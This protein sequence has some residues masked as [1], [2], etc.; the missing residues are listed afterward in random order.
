[1]EP[2]LGTGI[3]AMKIVLKLVIDSIRNNMD[4][5]EN[6][7]SQ[8]LGL[9]KDVC[10]LRD[11]IMKNKKINPHQVKLIGDLAH[12]IRD[13][14][15]KS[16]IHRS[17][18]KS[19]Y[20]SQTAKLDLAKNVQKL[21]S[22]VSAVCDGPAG[23]PTTVVEEDEPPS[24]IPLR[25]DNVVGFEDEAKK[26]INYLMEE[27]DE[28]DV[29]SIVGMPGL[30][31]STL[32]YKIHKDQD[33][34]LAPKFPASN[35]IWVRVQPRDES[36]DVLRSILRQI[37]GVVIGNQILEASELRKR[38]RDN[39]WTLGCFLITIDDVWSIK[40]WKD[41]ENAFP[42]AHKAG[43]IL[44][45]SQLLDVARAVNRK[46][47][48]HKLRFLT[49]IECREL[50][51][52]EVF[53]TRECEPGQDS[54]L[55]SVST[56]CDGLPHLILG[57]AESVHKRDSKW[58]SE[59]FSS[60][61][62]DFIRSPEE[63]A[64][65]L[66]YNRLPDHLKLCFLYMGIFPESYVL[67][68]PTYEIPVWVL[69]R[70][71]LAEDF[72][73]P[74]GEQVA[75]DYLMDLVNRNL[76]MMIPGMISANESKH[77]RVHCMVREFCRYEAGYDRGNVFQE[78]NFD[79]G[80]FQPSIADLGNPRRLRIGS[81]V[82]GFFRFEKPPPHVSSFICFST[83]DLE[84]GDN[85]SSIPDVLEYLRV[86]EAKSITYNKSWGDWR[87]MLLLKHLVLSTKLHV[88]PKVISKLWSLETLVVHTTASVLK[89]EAN[90]YDMSYL[91]H[92]ET[93]KPT[94]LPKPGKSKKHNKLLTLGTISDKSCTE[95]M[96]ARLGRLQ[97]LRIHG[98]IYEV[99]K[100]KSL[101][102]LDSLTKLKFENESRSNQP[103]SKAKLL[104]SYKFPTNLTSLTLS[105]TRL[106]WSN[107]SALELL[108]RLE[109]LKLKNN[110][111]SGH[112]WVVG[113]AGF[114]KLEVLHIEAD[115]QQWTVDGTCFQALRFLV[116]IDCVNLEEIP[117]NLAEN[118]SLKKLWLQ[119]VEQLESS[120]FHI[121][122][123]KR[124]QEQEDR[125]SRIKFKLYIN[126]NERNGRQELFI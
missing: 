56:K 98:R 65:S 46:R 26:I 112:S 21:R 68:S 42:K 106:D 104:D 62:K 102:K 52:L 50:L 92:V 118:R 12:Q 105:A 23:N 7:D 111:F 97:K 15:D 94:E 76:V 48:P 82:K 18:A 96:F 84:P 28:L 5:I 22:K 39:L 13:E 20:K 79:R 30:G 31:K 10:S 126:G 38:V 87:K 27:K 88:I 58:V 119:N 72:I 90:I 107:M 120:A 71:W 34:I 29:V 51:Q 69:I 25:E 4:M 17:Q 109:K 80:H 57:I 78:I 1:M 14:I 122:E 19:W 47:V 115:L 32:A 53:G 59:N 49:Q 114:P 54:Y 116:I 83:E 16:T 33:R 2:G 85:C 89:V 95:K 103:S 24:L 61:V 43:K 44:I 63:R 100:D 64:Y 124:R 117:S 6:A 125:S 35:R 121:L 40:L 3:E 73:H 77:C 75:H 74:K 66:S 60:C 45:T 55:D 108:T 9:E 113:S 101:A 91:E 93:N 8:L 81:N 110:A 123:E 41:L 86:L 70:L 11:Y 37:P 99:L 36:S 67:N